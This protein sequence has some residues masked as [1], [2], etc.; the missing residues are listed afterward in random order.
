MSRPDGKRIALGAVVLI[1]L[2]IVI[3][4]FINV[5][6]YKA[7][8]TEAISN[9]LARPVSVGAISLRLLPQPGFTLEN[10]VVGD[11]P[12]FSAEPILRAEEVRATLRMTSLWR[13]K[14]EIARLS[15]QYPSL[16]L[17]RN[18]SGRLNLESLLAR[19]S[20]VRAAPTTARKPE[21][22]PRF[23]YIEAE[24]GRINFKTG[25]EKKVLALTEADFSL[26]SPWE[27]EW[28]MRLEA[29]AVRTDTA[30]NDSGLLTVEGSFHRAEQLAQTPLNVKWSLERGQLGQI[31][32]LIYGRD[33]GWRGSVATSGSIT[34]VLGVPTFALQVAVDD[35]RRY[36]IAGGGSLR[37]A[38]QCNGHLNSSSGTTT[39]FALCN[40]PVGSGQVSTELSFVRGLDEYTIKTSINTIP[41]QSLVAFA[42]HA[43]RGVPDD[44]SATGSLTGLFYFS[45]AAGKFSLT[46]DGAATATDFTLKSDL[47]GRD[48]ALGNVKFGY[49]TV[50]PRPVRVRGAVLTS[51]ADP[52]RLEFPKFQ[53]ALG[54]NAPLVGNAWVSP[55][56]YSLSLH[57]D[58]EL[59]RLMQVARALGIGVPHFQAFGSTR[60]AIAIDGEWK[61]F[62]QP[63]AR[64]T[65]QLRNARAEIPGIAQPVQIASATVSLAHDE[66]RV[67]NLAASADDVTL[68]G[69]AVFPRSCE[70]DI[71]CTSQLQLQF[72]EIDPEKLNA[73]L[74]PRLKQR[75]WYRFF[76]GGEREESA[77]ARIEAT[78]RI[79]ARRL[80]LRAVSATRLATDFNLRQGKLELTN[81][82]ADLLGGTHTGNWTADFS[83][84]EPVYRGAGSLS[85][86]SVAQ[87][88]TVMKDAWAVGT[89]TASFKFSMSGWTAKDFAASADA[90]AQLE[91]R[92]GTLRHIAL[93]GRGTPLQFSSFTGRISLSDGRIHLPESK[94]VT[95]NGI[96]Q[97][98]GTAT[99]N[100]ELE[101]Q[102]SSAGGTAYKVTGT[103]EKPQIVPLPAREAEASLKR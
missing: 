47:L 91:M 30:M 51:P 96:Y 80:V 35:F 79:T 61:G 15:L 8:I 89:L 12:A 88:A 26:W 25:L 31:T 85:R 17:V 69:N 92:D 4:P 86:V 22:R 59:S 54:A 21:S 98:S 3:P 50:N 7:R 49:G 87:L 41:L 102:M 5:S 100:R 37:L 33:R 55:D 46:M 71:P 52:S 56:G 11:D 63:S 20:Q 18:H 84:R 36:D 13:G 90:D 95:E 27:D 58:A 9:S 75:P 60:V 76:G 81:L 6:R 101:L 29:R 2:A 43:K 97:V 67:Q 14:F 19:A 73:L 53:L 64:G 16:N 66:L 39:G 40:A 45:R 23:P 24:G 82:R 42:R 44:L 78:G 93:G 32:K 77:L 1:I 72:D 34:G 70:Q 68:T 62:A 10:F 28:R 38:V 94:L 74:N 57:G 103:L 99:L 48:L 65:L 83:A